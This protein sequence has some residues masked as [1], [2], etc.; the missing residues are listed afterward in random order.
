MKKETT[1]SLKDQLFNTQT[2]SQLAWWFF[3][4]DDRFPK[5]SFIYD[6]ITKFPVLELKQRITHITQTLHH[7]LPK[8]YPQALEVILRTL[9]PELDPTKTDDE[10]GSFIITPLGEYISTYWCTQEY[11][12]ISCHAQCYQ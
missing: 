5:D 7:Y 4:N 12:E 1:F 3:T 10:F 11:F 2:V 9:P 6:C 8:D